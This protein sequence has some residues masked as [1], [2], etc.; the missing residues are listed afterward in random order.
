MDRFSPISPRSKKAKKMPKTAMGRW[1]ARVGLFWEQYYRYILSVLYILGVALVLFGFF[2]HFNRSYYYE[3]PKVMLT[4]PRDIKIVGNSLMPKNILEEYVQY[5]IYKINEKRTGQK[6]HV[7]SMTISATELM[8]SDFVDELK[9]NLTSVRDVRMQFDP[10]KR[11]VTLTIE[12]RLPI[13]QLTTTEGTMLVADIEGVV[14]RSS[15]LGGNHYPEI[16]VLPEESEIEPGNKLPD[17]YQCMLHLIDANRRATENERLPEIARVAFKY[18]DPAD[19]ILVT[20]RD[21]RRIMMYWKNMDQ[22][23]EASP[24]M[25]ELMRDL[26]GILSSPD[27]RDI[28]NFTAIYGEKKQITATLPVVD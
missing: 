10:V 4:I 1:F 27:A 17:I 2:Y 12:E 5:A 15:A 26:N 19:G 20:L 22:E 9:R 23:A 16:V 3:N 7:S 28:E 21:G 24:K 25:L 14:F 18:E 8:E 13:L 6:Q 11:E